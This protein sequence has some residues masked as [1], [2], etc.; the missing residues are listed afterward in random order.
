MI[1]SAEVIILAVVSLVQDSALTI[2]VAWLG[3][4][5]KEGRTLKAR[6]VAP[7]VTFSATAD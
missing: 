6:T 3:V 2:A 5:I 7:S 1:P 4:E